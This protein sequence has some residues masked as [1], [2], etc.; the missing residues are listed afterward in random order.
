MRVLEKNEQC[1]SREVEPTGDVDGLTGYI[2]PGFRCQPH[3]GTSVIGSVAVPAERYLLKFDRL[4][5]IHR[6]AT[7]LGICFYKSP[8]H[9]SCGETR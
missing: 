2:R 4:H 3:D 5:L 7:G 6:D 1:K 9:I 8:V